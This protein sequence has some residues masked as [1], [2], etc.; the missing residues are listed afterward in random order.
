VSG[1]L[2]AASRQRPQRRR[3]G[4]RAETIVARYRGKV[5]R[6]YFQ[7]G[8][9]FVNPEAMSF[10]KPSASSMRSGFRQQH[11]AGE[12]RLSAGVADWTTSKR[13]AAILRQ[14]AWPIGRLPNEVRRY[15][16]NLTY[17]AGSDQTGL[18][19]LTSRTRVNPFFSSTTR[20]RPA[21]NRSRKGPGRAEANAAFVTAIA[22]RS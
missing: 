14:W 9:G 18:R 13:S 20:S 1:T 3:L 6:I 4:W 19:T 16:A 7:A 15:Y 17:Q 11:L 10:P 22:G 8:A 5:A 2:R 21:H 12:G